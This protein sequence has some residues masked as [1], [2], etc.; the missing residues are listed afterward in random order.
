MNDLFQA[1]CT[2]HV[3]I[4]DIN[5]NDPVFGSIY[6]VVV[7]EGA[8]NNTQLQLVSNTTTRLQLVSNT[9]IHDSTS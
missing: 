9:T 5:D 6:H 4:A 2:V 7:S 3:Q 8:A 1:T